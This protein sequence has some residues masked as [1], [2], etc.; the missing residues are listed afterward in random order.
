MPAGPA[1]S[2]LPGALHQ[3]LER[4]ALAQPD[5]EF[6]SADG[7]TWTYRQLDQ[8][9]TLVAR[10]LSRRGIGRGDRVLLMM[11]SS[12]IYLASWFGISKLGAVEVPVNAAYRGEILRHILL[13]A[14][15][16]I[17]FVA[18]EYRAQFEEPAQGLFALSEIV[19]PQCDELAWNEAQADAL[20]DTQLDVEV[21][22]T[23][24]ACVVF[25]SGTTGLSKGVVMSHHHQITFAAFFSEVVE[26]AAT[27]VAY[28]FLPFFHVA[29][30][31]L[32]IGAMLAGARMIMRAVFS[33]S[34]FW[35][36]VR[37]GQATVCIAVGG[38]CHI[39]NGAP[40]A[41]GDAD[42][43]LRLI[44]SVPVPWEFKESF[45]ARFGLRLIE[46]YGR[47]ESN[48]NIC[49]GLNEETPRGSC[50]RASPHF[51]V[52]I[53]DESGVEVPRGVAGEIWARAKEP[54]T[55]MIGYLGPPELTVQTMHGEWMK[56]GDRAYMDEQG[57]VFFV[58]RIKDAIR[59]RG[60][61]ISSVEVE[62]AL[63]TH[64]SI[65]E[66][67]VIPVKAEVGEDE[68]KAVVVLKPGV[69]LAPEAL[70]EFAIKSLPYFMVP[71]FIEF[72]AELPRTPTMRVKKIALREEG[73]TQATWDCEKA[74]LRITG[75]GLER[76]IANGPATHG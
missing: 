59:R 53:R 16:K 40:A 38:L 54:N 68:V 31:F 14:D 15:A 5:Q 74:G 69:N 32:A 70:L 8:H 19:D 2:N 41:A 64:P 39:L 22:A 61:N 21:L 37:E 48:L 28:N 49:C 45:E 51:D 29:A 35:R 73:C 47:T 63:N 46:A 33:A 24:P 50:G 17:A 43:P 13:T 3:L 4:Q 26:F 71:R 23:D 36:D 62:R 7:R 75:R 27:D 60:E 52:S 44:Y 10:A 30:K 34:H 72:K 57:Y 42:N 56:S 55:M 58:D 9:A 12:E 11:P 76:I 65:E 20:T 67:A 66:V 6:V 1:S 18:D 25:T